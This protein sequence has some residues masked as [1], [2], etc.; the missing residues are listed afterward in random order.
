MST[1]LIFPDP[2]IDP[3]YVEVPVAP[4]KFTFPELVRFILFWTVTPA[5]ADMLLPEAKLIVPVPLTWLEL[6]FRTRPP[7]PDLVIL[8]SIIISPC[9]SKVKSL[10][11]LDD[12]EFST[13][14]S[15]FWKPLFPVKTVILL[16]ASAVSKVPTSTTALLPVAV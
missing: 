7:V 6:A 10:E 13:V 16:D 9:E 5:S 3:E 11:L 12:M 1:L 15:P 14:I 8:A 2:D 4:P